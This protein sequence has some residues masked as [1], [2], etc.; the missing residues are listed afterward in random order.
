[1]SGRILWKLALMLVAVIVAAAAMFAFSPLRKW[2]PEGIRL[3][4]FGE[5]KVTLVFSVAD[6][7]ARDDVIKVFKKRV[8]I[9][10]LWDAK[11]SPQGDREIRVVGWGNADDLKSMLVT[12]GTL[13]FY[14]EAPGKV[15]KEY[16]EAHGAAARGAKV[17]PPAGF[18]IVEGKDSEGNPIRGLNGRQYLLLYSEVQFQASDFADFRLTTYEGKPAV[19]FTL[20]VSSAPKFAA[21]TKKLIN[22][23]EYGVEHGRLAMYVNGAFE[24]A[25]TVRSIISENGIITLG[26]LDPQE[27]E[28]KARNLVIALQSGA[29]DV[30]VTL[31]SET[32]EGPNAGKAKQRNEK[33]APAGADFGY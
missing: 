17:E 23:D 21:V 14:V 11:I 13:K 28:T 19:D 2:L 31:E 10:G 20:S 22:E 25:P 5:T 7:S 18:K 4:V 26:G 32:V 27:I 29:L 9:A 1:M 6:A 3:N 8:G 15:Y 24:S 16:D 12:I 33:K 30:P